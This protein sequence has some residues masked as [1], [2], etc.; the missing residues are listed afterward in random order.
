MADYASNTP[1]SRA[2]NTGYKADVDMDGWS[3]S[4]EWGMFFGDPVNEM[5]PL[6]A[7]APRPLPTRRWI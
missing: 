7:P 1:I 3:W 4:Y 5:T 2:A 6:R